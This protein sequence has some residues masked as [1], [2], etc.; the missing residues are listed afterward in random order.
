MDSTELRRERNRTATKNVD[1]ADQ[2]NFVRRAT[3]LLASPLRGCAGVV[4]RAQRR[5]QRPRRG[6]ERMQ[7]MAELVPRVGVGVLVCRGD[8]VLVGKRRSSVGGGKY[9][10]PGGFLDF[11]KVLFPSSRACFLCHFS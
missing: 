1:G 8:H 10:L 9:A 4:K 2:P 6:S 3:A 11:G 7:V 5:L